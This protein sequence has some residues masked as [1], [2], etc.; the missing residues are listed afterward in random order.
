MELFDRSFFITKFGFRS[1]ALSSDFDFGRTISQRIC[2]CMGPI[3][4]PEE[5]IIRRVRC[6][7]KFHVRHLRKGVVSGA[8][9]KFINIFSMDRGFVPFT[10]KANALASMA[11]SIRLTDT[12]SRRHVDQV[13]QNRHLRD[14]R[15]PAPG[16]SPSPDYE[17]RRIHRDIVDTQTRPGPAQERNPVVRLVRPM[18]A[19]TTRPGH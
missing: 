10:A 6:P 8:I 7:P 17:T 1:Y 16:R 11:F 12:R 18:L 2:Q 14:A 15:R 19:R 4:S 9:P 5:A 3:T 13:V